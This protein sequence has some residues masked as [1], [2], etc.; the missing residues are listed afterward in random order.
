[1]TTPVLQAEGLTKTYRSGVTAVD[2]VSLHI[3]P[4]ECLGL[5]GQSGSGKSTLSRCLLGLE[6]LDSGTMQL[7][8]VPLRPGETRRSM[9]MVFQHPA[10]SFNSRLRLRTS[11]LEPLHCDP[12]RRREVLDSGTWDEDSYLRH[13][14]DL[15]Q[16]DAGL[17]DR[18]PRQLS[19]GQLQRMAIARALAARPSLIVLDE[20]TASLDVSVQATVLTLLKDL[21]A[22][23]GLALLFISHDLAAVASVSHRI[24]V[25]RHGRI[26]DCFPTEAIDAPER[27]DYTRTLVDLFSD[28]DSP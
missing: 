17:A 7:D 18:L 19:G 12:S 24:A 27:A 28:E 14:L 8:G 3:D 26:V 6:R 2:E 25:M 21:Q 15:V 9:Q 4:G 20:P 22:Q 16:L 10:A 13:L 23:L 1:M 11:L 5:V